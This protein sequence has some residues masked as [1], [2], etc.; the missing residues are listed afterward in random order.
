ML[1]TLTRN[2][3]LVID[4]LYC[5]NLSPPLNEYADLSS[6]GGF[7]YSFRLALFSIVC[8]VLGC[9]VFIH[10]FLFWLLGIRRALLRNDISPDTGLPHTMVLD[11]CDDNNLREALFG[12]GVGGCSVL[13]KVIYPSLW[14]VLEWLDLLDP[15]SWMKVLYDDVEFS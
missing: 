9:I 10:S 13:A 15:I 8:R 3:G 4:A 2:S 7:L 14:I 11:A 5:S 1:L 12:W 6:Q